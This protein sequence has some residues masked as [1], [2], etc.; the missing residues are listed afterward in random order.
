MDGMSAVA[1]SDVKPSVG[2]GGCHRVSAATRLNPTLGTTFH[3]QT[4][5]LWCN[6]ATDVTAIDTDGR[7]IVSLIRMDP[8]TRACKS[9]YEYVAGLL[10]KDRM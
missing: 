3:K 9:N 7:P 1:C 4:V 10:A 8:W 6:L 2:T 5:F